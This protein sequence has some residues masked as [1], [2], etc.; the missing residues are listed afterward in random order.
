MAE[1]RRAHS[2]PAS[3]CKGR[4]FVLCLT[5]VKDSNWEPD[6]VTLL[7]RFYEGFGG[8]HHMLVASL[9][10]EILS[11]IQKSARSLYLA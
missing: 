7:V 4:P 3:P 1:V 11:L 10:L 8:L 6:G 2:G 5:N 9:G